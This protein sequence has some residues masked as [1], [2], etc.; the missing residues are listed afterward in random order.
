MTSGTRRFIEVTLCLTAAFVVLAAIVTSWATPEF[1]RAGYLQSPLGPVGPADQDLLIRV[2]Q[3]GLWEMPVGL[4]AANRAITPRFR[5][6]G[7]KMATEHARLDQLVEDVARQL[8]VPLPTEP[9]DEQ[10]A[11]M[12]QITESRGLA[13]DKTAVMLLRQAHG[14]ILPA[15]AAVRA[16]TRNALIRQFAE[17]SSAYVL[18]H[19]NYLESTGFVEYD[20]LP[21]PPAPAP[22]AQP[23]SSSY[24]DRYDN[25]TVFIAVVVILLLLLLV[26]FIV[27]QLAGQR[28]STRPPESRPPDA[29]GKHARR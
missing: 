5:E 14:K 22:A 21:E 12:Q 16:G 4:E 15:I 6:V 27:R 17:E 8:D 10:K 18:R 25:R 3:A 20:Q 26:I 28:R 11:W 13:Y 24:L 9:T 2:K 1:A 23:V 7:A 19:I 29:A